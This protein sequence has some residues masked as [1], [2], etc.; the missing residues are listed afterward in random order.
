MPE[1]NELI[2]ERKNP[3]NAS[4]ERKIITGMIISDRFLREVKPLLLNGKFQTDFT[5]TV[6][7]WCLDYYDS[8]NQAPQKNIEEIFLR[9]KSTLDEERA[10]LI[11]DFLTG[12]SDDFE[13][14]ENFNTDY[15]LDIA[16]EYFRLTNLKHIHQELGKAI[17]GGRID[18]GE[19][20]I[21]KYQRPERI[22]SKGVDPLRDIQFISESTKTNEEN[23]DILMTLPGALGQACGPLE[24]GYSMAFQAESGVGKTWW[25]WFL[26]KIGVFRGFNGIF[27]SLEMQ[28][29]KMGRRIWQ[30]LTASPTLNPDVLIP[31]FDCLYN[32][33]N[34]CTLSKRSC[35]ICLVDKNGKLPKP[36][37]TPRGYIPCSACRDNWDDSKLTSWWKKEERN[38]LDPAIAVHKY[39]Q[40]KRS[41]TLTK[42][43]KFHLV[44][45]P[46]NTLTVDKMIAYVNNLE[47]Y[48]DFIVDFFIT[49]YADKFKLYNPNDLYGSLNQIWD[50]HKAL[51]Q[52]KHCLSI[53][54][55]QSNTERTGKK[56]GKGSWAGSIEKRRGI[57]LGIALNQKKEDLEKGLIYVEIDKMRHEQS[58]FA[59]VAVLQQLAIGRPYIDSCF[60]RRGK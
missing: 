3:V 17:T 35:N 25:L 51:A 37:E 42:A 1:L 34:S 49:D 21:K 47:F 30:D 11:E 4:Q 50:A 12:L 53:T 13:R 60:V 19:A 41:G 27:M 33:T 20:L 59:E 52:E 46:T 54:A 55:S 2:R 40:L 24:R 14:S 58:I 6:A 23:P 18:E 26:S 9:N 7:D 10:N 32:Q 36:E 57:D 15:F 45:F 44:E 5:K 16:E 8:Y 56:V 39:E 28:E 43:G 22:K 38:I 31:S 29:R 48:D